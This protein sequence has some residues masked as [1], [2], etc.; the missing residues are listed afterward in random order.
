VQTDVVDM[1]HFLVALKRVDS[2]SKSLGCFRREKAFGTTEILWYN[3]SI[4]T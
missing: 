2:P 3:W 4:S 1:R